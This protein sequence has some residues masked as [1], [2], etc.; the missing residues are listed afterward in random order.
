M[1]LVLRNQ[2]R[3]IFQIH[4]LDIPLNGLSVLFYMISFYHFITV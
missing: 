3:I 1:K 4:C 2:F